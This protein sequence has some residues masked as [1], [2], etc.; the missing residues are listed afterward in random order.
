MT[1][2]APLR[3]WHLTSLDAPT[4]AVVW[5]LGFAW[6]GRITLPLWL[7]VVLALAGWSFYILDRLLDARRCLAPRENGQNAGFSP[8]L[9]RARHYFHWKHRRMFAPVAAVAAGL[10][11]GLVWHSMPVAARARNSVLA[12][13]AMAYFTSVHSPWRP[14]SRPSSSRRLRLPK[15]LL[16][17][18]LFTLACA[19]PV[20]TR[21]A[22]GRAALVA[23]VLVY[24]ALA[25]LNCVAI[26]TWESR[27][28]STV[29]RMALA[30]AGI[31][32]LAAGGGVALHL[33]RTA[34]LLSAAALSGGALATLDRL[35]GRLDPT[36][37][38]MAADL[39]LLT[40]LPLLM[41]R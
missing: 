10:A 3:L 32:I 38:R 24:T 11:I 27:G 5:C 14:A 41:L 35:R 36:T 25:W 30:L 18:I 26:E 34:L 17:G 31:A 9:L 22:E 23:P 8:T 37:L 13:A 39:V 20:W 33:P 6:A 16:V 21:M 2:P 4:V 28:R 40:P 12:A 29:F 15:E 19:M 1:A 7:P